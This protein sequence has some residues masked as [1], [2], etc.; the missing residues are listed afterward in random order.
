MIEC[1][2]E[3]RKER[4]FGKRGSGSIIAWALG[5]PIRF[6]VIVT[7]ITLYFMGLGN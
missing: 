6:M 4:S 1:S 2:Y 3:D 7:I 5:L